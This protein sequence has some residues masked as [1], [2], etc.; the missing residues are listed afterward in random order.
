VTVGLLFQESLDWKPGG[1]TIMEAAAGR[2]RLGRFF[3]TAKLFTGWQHDG[4]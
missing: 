2:R 1:L 3:G 4:G